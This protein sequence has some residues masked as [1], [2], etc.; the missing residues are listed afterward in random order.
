MEDDEDFEFS[1]QGKRYVHI[2]QIND[3][4]KFNQSVINKLLNQ[5]IGGNNED[6]EFD[7]TVG[8]L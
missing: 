1:A 5:I 4:A 7:Q 6:D 3:H 8:V 2:K